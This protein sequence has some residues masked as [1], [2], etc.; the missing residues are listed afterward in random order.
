MFFSLVNET[1]HLYVTWIFEKCAG[2]NFLTEVHLSEV[3]QIVR[4]IEQKGL[5]RANNLNS[6]STIS[7]FWN[8][9]G[10]SFVL[11]A[12]LDE[13]WIS[14]SSAMINAKIY[15]QNRRTALL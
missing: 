13:V 3:K 5:M 1:W 7:E 2:Q 8:S 6:Y 14:Y 12:I 9:L 10:H 15:F 4:V 11:F